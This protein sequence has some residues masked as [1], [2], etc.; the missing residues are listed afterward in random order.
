MAEMRRRPSAQLLLG[1]GLVLVP[2]YIILPVVT[3][4]HDVSASKSASP[5]G[6]QAA[7]VVWWEPALGRKKLKEQK[8]MLVT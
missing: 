5:K 2:R 1:P 3:G 7:G 6:L 8:L 4:L